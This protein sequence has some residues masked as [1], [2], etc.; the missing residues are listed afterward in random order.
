MAIFH[1]NPDPP[2]RSEPELHLLFWGREQCSPGHAFGPGV[3]DYYKIHF[4]HGGRGVLQAAGQT[5]RLEAGQAFLTYPHQKVY[6]EADRGQPWLYSWIA[7]TG[8]RAEELLA[9]TS[10]TPAEPVF[11]AD[12]EPMEELYE[13]LNEDA[14]AGEAADLLLM[15]RLYEFLA[16]LVRTMPAR[17]TGLS[18]SRRTN[19]HVA[20]S[21]RY[22]HAHY[23][24]DISVE[25]MAEQLQL[26]RKYL[27]AL[28][29]RETG[30]PPRQYLLD[31]R[32]AKAADLLIRTDCTVGEI[33][34]SVGYRDSLL[35]SR[36][37]KRVRGLSPRAYRERNR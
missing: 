35:F 15:G 22:L 36:M 24:E 1:Y 29:K 10:L 18:G 9:R 16:A 7:F 27:S 6:Y 20:D 2:S 3:R 13:R 5:R 28:F 25:Q 31:Y 33:A 17:E 37:F 19:A 23:C 30:V 21:L 12:G 26:D 14:R 11:P 32:M 4:I 34:R 8:S